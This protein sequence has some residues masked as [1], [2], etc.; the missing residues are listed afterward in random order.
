[1]RGFVV[2]LSLSS[3]WL[4]CLVT[5]CSNESAYVADP[6]SQACL[7]CLS[8][9]ESRGCAAQYAACEEVAACDDYVVCQLSGRCLEQV[10][11][12]GCEQ[13]LDCKR[14]SSSGA[15]VTS[16]G[17]ASPSPRELAAAFEK[18]ARTT[19]AANCGF[20]E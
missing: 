15:D 9:R 11:G 17:G 19:C 16:D 5:G 12:S 18:C 20:V 10:P 13:E 8:E 3:V 4:S 1:M 7:D 6:I 14:P 2:G